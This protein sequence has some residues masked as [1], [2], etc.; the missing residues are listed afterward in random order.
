M[1]RLLI[2]A[3]LLTL[4]TLSLPA[5]QKRGE[6]ETEEVEHTIVV[7]SP[8]KKSVTIT[9]KYV[10]VIH[11]SIHSEIEA[12][13]EGYLLEIH[14]KEGQAV[15]KGDPIFEVNPVIY[16]AE[17]ATDMAEAE[18]AEIEYKNTLALYEKSVN[19]STV[20]SAPQLA[21]A[22]AKLTRAQA[23][24]AKSKANLEFATV[25]APFDG[26]IDRLLLQQGSLIDKGDILTTISNNAKMWVYF[27]V[28]EARYLEYMHNM[29]Q[30]AKQAE[31][32]DE[33]TA[34]EKDILLTEI[35]TAVKDAVMSRYPK[36]KLQ[37]AV[38]ITQGDEV[39]YDVKILTAE[40]KKFQLKI[41]KDG[42]KI[43]VS[44]SNQLKESQK[45]E[46]Q[47]ADGSI[48]SETGKNDCRD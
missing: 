44:D 18:L 2:S 37:G 22:K 25:K 17:L 6:G 13:E 8:V 42:T 26:I 5:C 35:P 4:L 27:N 21:M 29:I 39:E 14:V 7:T 38:L 16:K 24:V 12:L 41:S 40:N 20:V 31:E 10:C 46:L 47:L 33:E 15:K 23:N 48:Y 43:E 28:P 34:V 32:N 30:E 11:S 45:I 1:K 3:S 19:G 9:E 36:S